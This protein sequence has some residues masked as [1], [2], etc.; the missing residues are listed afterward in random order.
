MRLGTR[1][2]V[3]FHGR[4]VGA[5]VTEL[6]TEPP[7]GVA[8]RE[9]QRLSGYG[10]PPSVLAL[11][12]W[13]AWRFAMPLAT[14]L[15]TASPER[16]VWELP[17]AQPWPSR[18][19]GAAP[20][21]GP[22][23]APGAKV[24]LRREPPARDLLDIV[25]DAVTRADGPVLVLTPSTGW[26]ER[27]AARLRGRGLDVASSWAEAAAGWPVV[28]GSRAAAWAPIP[29][30]G[31]A[32]VLD[33]H[34]QHDR[35]DAT[36]VVVERALRDGAPCTLVSPCPTAVQRVRYGPVVA[37]ERSVER[38]G[39]PALTVVDRRVADP[40]TGLLSEELVD[41]ARRVRPERLLCLLHRTG[42]ARLLACGTCG[43][44]ARCERC[45][46]PVESVGEALSCRSCGAERPQ[47]CASCGSGR[48]K[49]LRQ[50]VSR[51]R[52]ELEALL[53]VPV[54]EVTGDTGT[55]VPPT[56][57][58]V[59]T[60]AV[61]HRVRRAAAV[62]FLDFDQH[63]LAPRFSAGEESLALLARAARL[64][65]GRQ[66]TV[67]VQTRLPEHDVL[68]AAVAGDPGL[69]T[70]LD[71]RRELSLPPYSALATVRAET[72]PV[73]ENTEVSPLGP[74][75]WLV[76]A[77]DHQTLCD[78]VADLHGGVRIDPHDV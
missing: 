27:L 48:L 11:A 5:W 30:L 43:A 13:A 57:V 63:L 49:V 32:V 19:A 3:P 28:V 74:G 8:L 39:W 12:Q 6:D 40:R 46:R 38:A 52:E 31:A 66:G 16:N 59:G 44:L 35:Y 18:A 25:L 51:V 33:C 58:L 24:T 29:V 17:A 2:R 72:A 23:P 14:L 50:G 65:G 76:R 20:G 42:R 34:D 21:P 75:R 7:P 62:A 10:P 56:Q 45:G 22:A 36:D 69:Y 15:R 53:S 1:V 9:V 37:E 68:R 70:E 26:S 54:G 61:L 55:Q 47:V 41:L 64:V 78:A 71:L 4:R 77:P 67:L 60:E 73:L